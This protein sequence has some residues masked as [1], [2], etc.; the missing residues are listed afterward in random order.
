MAYQG[1]SSGHVGQGGSGGG[2]GAVLMVLLLLLVV[3]AAQLEVVAE[4][5]QQSQAHYP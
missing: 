5:L 2:G 1:S 4:D 3:G